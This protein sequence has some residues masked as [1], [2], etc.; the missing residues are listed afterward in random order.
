[1]PHQALT[2]SLDVPRRVRRRAYCLPDPFPGRNDPQIIDFVNPG[3]LRATPPRTEP[4]AG[5]RRRP[6]ARDGSQPLDP[7]P[8]PWI[9]SKTGLL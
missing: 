5:E 8:M 4:P 6:H 7:K 1:M 3:E 9:R 2:R